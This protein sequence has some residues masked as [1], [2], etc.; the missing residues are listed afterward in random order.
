MLLGALRRTFT[1]FKTHE[2]IENRF[3]VHKLKTKMHRLAVDN[4][5]VC[6]CH[7]VLYQ[8]VNSFLATFV[9][10]CNPVASVFSIL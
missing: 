5:V 3:I 2:Q 1:E 10:H 4:P 7:K 9:E 6:N 8:N